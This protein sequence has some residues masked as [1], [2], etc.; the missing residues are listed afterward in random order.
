MDEAKEILE[1]FNAGYI[2]REHRPELSKQLESSLGEV[3][4][5]FF[6]GFISGGR[7]FT[8]EQTKSKNISRFIKTLRESIPKPP[9]SKGRSNKGVDKDI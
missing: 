2:L 1:G 3:E 9:K 4:L 5:P 7:E 8:K 6:E